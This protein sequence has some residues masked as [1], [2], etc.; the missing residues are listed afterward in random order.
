MPLARLT[1]HN[2]DLAIIDRETFDAVQQRLPKRQGSSTPRPKGGRFLLTGLIRCGKCGRAMH[3]RD[4]GHDTRDV[5]S[6]DFR[7]GSSCCDRNSS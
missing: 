1:I 4:Y 5:C 6:A 3:G 7:Q 2:I